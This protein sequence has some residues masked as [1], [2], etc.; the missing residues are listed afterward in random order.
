MCIRDSLRDFAIQAMTE[1]L[2]TMEYLP[3]N[4]YNFHPG[5]HVKQGAETGIRLIAEGLNRILHPKMCIRDSLRTDI[6]IVQQ[7]IG[8]CKNFTVV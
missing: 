1:D 3:G 5:S 2:A 4:L 6:I 8:K 7:A